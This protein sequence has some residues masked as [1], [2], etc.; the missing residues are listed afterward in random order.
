M[1]EF[2]RQI[3]AARMARR[4]AVVRHGLET[5]YPAAAEAMS[6]VLRRRIGEFV[7]ERDE[8]L[9]GRDLQRDADPGWFQRSDQIGYVCYADRFAGSLSGVG[10]HL[11][12]LCDLGVTYLHLM[13]VLRAR[14]GENDGGYAVVAYDEVDPSLGSMDDLAELAGVLHHNGINLCVD[15]VLNHTA[16]EH[17]WAQRAR[18]GEATYRDY[19][20]FFPDRTMPD[21]YERTLREV[22]P[23][24]A[25]DNFTWLDD[26]EQWVW[27]TFHEFQWDLNWSNPQVFAEFVDVMLNLASQGVDVLRLD[28]APFLW[29]R[30]GTS[31][32][33]QPEVHALLTTMRALLAIAAPAT[34]FK[35]EAIVAPEDLLG[36]LG[37]GEPERH[38]C[39]LGYDNQLM[40]QL[41]SSLAAKDTRVLGHAMRRL[42][43]MPAHAAWVNYAR[44]HDDIG[45]AV[46][47]EDAATA[48]WTGDAH[49]AF[50]NEFYAGRF[51]GSFAAGEVFQFNP[52]TGDGRISGTAAALC[53]IDRSRREGDAQGIEDGCRRLELMYSCVYAF[54]GI[55]LLYM[56]DE[57][58]LA[59]DFAYRQ[60][61][62]RRDD[63]RWMHRPSMRWDIAERRFDSS[64]VEARLFASMIALGEARRTVEALDAS[65]PTSVVDVGIGAVLC[66]SRTHPVHGR[67]VMLANFGDAPERIGLD[68][69]GLVQPDVAYSS[70]ARLDRG[71]ADVGAKGFIWLVERIAG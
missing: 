62:A 47:D 11:D 28:A 14:P 30:E 40:V 5:L 58:G 52:Q 19:Y 24:F 57:I 39:D 50:L 16:A 63:N 3:L 55:P 51:A 70:L 21:R 43:A 48:G 36:Y 2:R 6:D 53:G 8:R 22:F 59:N 38:E 27:T 68:Q 10:E 71:A 13:P 34:I 1:S 20:F 46:M 25:P 49:R 69:V 18:S 31:C 44:C 37:A 41:W 15:V 67:F 54:G 35:S 33:N 32:E 12:Y 65:T 26:C 60:D 9:F 7:A 61:P 64:T 29:K 23:T 17:P 42:G 45:W 66:Y 56:G 4:W